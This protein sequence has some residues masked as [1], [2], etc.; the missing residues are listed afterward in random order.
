MTQAFDP[1][2]ASPP[3]GAASAMLRGL[4]D[5][6]REQLPQEEVATVDYYGGEFDEAEISQAEYACPAVFVTCLGF[7]QAKGDRNKGRW[8]RSARMACFVATKAATREGRFVEAVDLVE[9]VMV[10]AQ[11]WRPVCP[12]ALNA[13]ANAASATQSEQISP[14][15]CIGAAE[16]TS[17]QA[18]NLYNRK[19]DRHK[20]AIW[21][22]SWWQDFEPLHG[23]D[24]SQLPSLITLEW[25]ST[26]GITPPAAAEPLAPLTQES[27][28]AL[29]QDF[30]SATLP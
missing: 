5:Y 19:T 2:H 13:E 20:H 7:D 17:F 26:L 29:D 16:P 28:V 14:Q 30:N 23:T 10:L 4:R 22:L 27:C 1:Y 18:E 6:L 21:V 8:A 15:I 9:R 12:P 11:E 25:D 3:A 24:P